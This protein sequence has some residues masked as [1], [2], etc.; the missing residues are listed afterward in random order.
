VKP[1]KRGFQLSAYAMPAC[2]LEVGFISNRSDLEAIL[3]GPRQA[4]FW[5]RLARGLGLKQKQTSA[6]VTAITEADEGERTLYDVTSVEIAG[7]PAKEVAHG[8]MVAQHGK[9]LFIR[10]ATQQ[11]NQ[12]AK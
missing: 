6:T 8:V 12:S 7:N 2:L 4:D 3:D 5:H 11:E 10:P 9:K 1:L